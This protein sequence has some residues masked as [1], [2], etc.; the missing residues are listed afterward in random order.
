MCGFDHELV[1]IGCSKKGG[2]EGAVCGTRLLIVLGAGGWVVPWPAWKTADAC[3]T[4]NLPEVWPKHTGHAAGRGVYSFLEVK[5]RP[6]MSELSIPAAG[7]EHAV[8]SFL[9]GRPSSGQSAARVREASQTF[10]GHHPSLLGRL[11][12]S[13]YVDRLARTLS[14]VPL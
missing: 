7:L 10:A 3:T 2:K 4:I 5:S 14:S 13:A 6:S 8:P 11:G 12:M 9:L 1:E